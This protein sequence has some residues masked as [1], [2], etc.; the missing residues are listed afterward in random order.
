MEIVI[1]SWV[2]DGYPII[3]L[4]EDGTDEDAIKEYF[5]LDYGVGFLEDKDYEISSARLHI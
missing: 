5:A 3:H 1:V 2:E 4:F